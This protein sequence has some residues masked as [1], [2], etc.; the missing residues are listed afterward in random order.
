MRTIRKT[1]KKSTYFEGEFYLRNRGMWAFPIDFPTVFIAYGRAIRSGNW[2][3][4]T[5]LNNP[6]Y[7]LD[8]YFD[9]K[10]GKLVEFW[11]AVFALENITW[12]DVEADKEKV[13]ALIDETNTQLR[14]LPIL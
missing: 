5:N 10:K 12:Q 11:D 1:N 13:L 8:N 6:Q 7:V 3:S 14:K 9:G 2:Q 4:C